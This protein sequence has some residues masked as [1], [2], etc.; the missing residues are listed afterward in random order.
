MD[1]S[2]TAQVWLLELFSLRFIADLQQQAHMEALTAS[3]GRNCLCRKELYE[4]TSVCEERDAQ[5]AETQQ[6]L[7]DARQQLADSHQVL[8]STQQQLAA[9]Q[10]QAAAAQGQLGELNERHM[11]L[12][13]E[14]TAAGSLAERQADRIAQLEQQLAQAQSAAQVGRS[15]LA[16]HIVN[17]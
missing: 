3:L 6:Q 4:K 12:L 13:E 2:P 10:Q 14:H 17:K 5:L 16:E 9:A 1:L 7:H 8:A 15:W 11:Q